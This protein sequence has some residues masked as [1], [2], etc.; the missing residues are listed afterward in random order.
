MKII[1]SG[2]IILSLFGKVQQSTV[3][4]KLSNLIIISSLSF[5]FSLPVITFGASKAA[6][7][8]SVHK[9]LRRG[10]DT[11]AK[12]FMTSFKSN[13][14]QGIALS[15][16]YIAYT[17]F[18]VFD[19]YFAF[20]GLG[21]VSLPSWYKIVALLLVLPGIFTFPF[22]FPYLSRY[23]DSVKTI[24]KNS[25]IFCA[26]HANHTAIILIVD[27]IAFVLSVVC[28]P[29]VL[30]LPAVASLIDM[31]M[32]EEDFRLAMQLDEDEYEKRFGNVSDDEGATDEKAED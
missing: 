18:S 9:C 24:L 3:M 10:S 20:N 7:Y 1:C 12:D 8:Y 23:N 15:L 13:L 19:I 27:L 29:L 25:F 28:L 6:L 5:V 14:G 16:I 26:S 30:I 17:A 32:V 11:P 4:N 2:G 22:V 31:G 21:T